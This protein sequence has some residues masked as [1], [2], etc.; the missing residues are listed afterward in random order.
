MANPTHTNPKHYHTTTTNTRHTSSFVDHNTTAPS[1][2][3][4]APAS[5]I[6]KL[7]P[8]M[9]SCHYHTHHT[10]T[11]ARTCQRQPRHIPRRPQH[12]HTINTISSHCRAIA[13]PELLSAP[14][15]THTTP[16]PSHEP[17]SVPATPYPS[18]TTTPP[19]HQH[20]HNAQHHRCTLIITATDHFELFPLILLALFELV[21]DKY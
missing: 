16:L 9:N 3:P 17:L 7:L 20:H 8:A 11:I 15:H 18:P 19:H 10:A 14:P 4:V 12:H 5:F 13:N 1:T 21:N 6:A 2:P